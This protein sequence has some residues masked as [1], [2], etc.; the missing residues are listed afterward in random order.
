MVEPHL[1]NPR[2]RCYPMTWTMRR[3]REETHYVLCCGYNVSTSQ[4][5]GQWI[6]LKVSCNHPCLSNKFPTLLN[7]PSHPNLE[8]KHHFHF[9]LDGIPAFPLT[10]C[11]WKCHLYFWWP[12]GHHY[13]Y[14]LTICMKSSWATIIAQ[15]SV[16][17]LVP[18]S[19]IELLFP[20]VRH[21]LLD[22]TFSSLASINFSLNL[23][24]S[25]CI[26][27]H[28]LSTCNI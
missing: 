16:P 17:S 8:Y 27:R 19:K 23:Q 22:L 2:Q 14:A 26:K 12:L 7:D 15:Y 3:D 24:Y 20:Q 6:V 9:Y 18:V 5:I 13:Y 11:Y 1:E 10:V 4:R 21:Q 25:Q 28:L